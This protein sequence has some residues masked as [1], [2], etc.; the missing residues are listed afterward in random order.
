MAIKLKKIGKFLK[1]RLSEKSTYV[2][3]AT[4]AVAFGAPE[5]GIAITKYA[6]IGM[7]ILGS[8]LVAVDTTAA[9]TSE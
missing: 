1:A 7:L 5:V 9:I 4:L 8:G 2:G 3:L 6:D